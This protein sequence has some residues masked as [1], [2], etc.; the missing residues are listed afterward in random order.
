MME[1]TWQDLEGARPEGRGLVGR[2][3]EGDLR[4]ALRRAPSP[5]AWPL[6]AASIL[7]HACVF[8]W[9]YPGGGA[10]PLAPPNLLDIRVA[11][12]MPG[13]VVGPSSVSAAFAEAPATTPA[14]D[15]A[16]AAPAPSQNVVA[17]AVTAARPAPPASTETR[18]AETAAPVP[19]VS[20]ST[21]RVLI[22][23]APVPDPARLAP[24]DAAHADSPDVAL[25]PAVRPET[26]P[27]APAAPPELAS[28]P[29]E[30]EA[31]AAPRAVQTDSPTA[32]E[33]AP[34]PTPAAAPP[35]TTQPRRLLAAPSTESGRTATPTATAA[36]P[37]SARPAAI[38]VLPPSEIAG[39][40]EIAEATPVRAYQAPEVLNT[41]PPP[42]PPRRP[43][44][45]L[46]REQNPRLAA[47]NARIANAPPVD[48][49]A[50][51]AAAAPRPQAAPSLGQ[52][53]ER[54]TSGRRVIRRPAARARAGEGAGR[55]IAR[56]RPAGPTTP[57]DYRGAGFW[58]PPP[59]YPS[60][61]RQRRLEG[62]VILRVQVTPA[63]RAGGV[64]VRRSS[65]HAV[66]DRA[67]LAA[68]RGWR[69]KPAL[70]D[71]VA[72]RARIDVPVTFRLR[73]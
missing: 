37:K 11:F 4:L 2:G 8:V 71:G 20:T 32:T 38:A 64:S 55:Q 73:P 26:S 30:T 44:S 59:A 50:T 70:K 49:T 5:S 13:D 48:Q 63:G 10:T 17:A 15:A 69:F 29:R 34:A 66:L 6:I 42:L 40:A 35:A 16:E 60:V 19:T 27:A 23:R 46:A 67:A 1:A 57:A 41:P 22:A 25:T 39:T 14:L 18:E 33:A 9:L 12:V 43:P 52:R 53:A 61:A 36:T 72:V 47:P 45:L 21:D 54:Q 58:N 56:V 7:L 28:A 51:A 62:Q 65:G 68:V 3:L 31:A 24:A